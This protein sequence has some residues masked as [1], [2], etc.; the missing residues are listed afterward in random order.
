MY[1]GEVLP[2]PVFDTFK[3]PHT[4]ILDYMFEI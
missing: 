1:S 3:I 2:V 4:G